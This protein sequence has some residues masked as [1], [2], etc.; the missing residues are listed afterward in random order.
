MPQKRTA[1]T[2]VACDS[3]R[4]RKVKCDGAQPICNRC[5]ARG[6]LSPCHYNRLHH[7]SLLRE[8]IS[9]LESELSR[10]KDDSPRAL[11]STESKQPPWSDLSGTAARRE[12]KPPCECSP[13]TSCIKTECSMLSP[14][15]DDEKLIGGF[16]REHSLGCAA[17]RSLYPPEIRAVQLSNRSK[18]EH[19]SNS[20]WLEAEKVPGMHI[21]WVNRTFL[22]M[23]AKGRWLAQQGL[24]ASAIMGDTCPTLYPHSHPSEDDAVDFWTVSRWATRFVDK[25]PNISHADRLACW[26]VIFVTFQWQICPTRETYRTIPDWYRPLDFQRYVPHMA[27]LDILIWPSARKYLAAHPQDFV[28]AIMSS[29]SVSWPHGDSKLYCTDLLTG[30]R[31]INPEFISW[32][33]DMEKWSVSEHTIASIPQLKGMIKTR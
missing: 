5:V 14:I 6:A 3:C 27:C 2:Q 30:K 9:Q 18:P 26:V 10:A 12:T 31:V 24:D 11:E 17:H 33:L 4:R 13:G 16:Y 1:V 15:T 19:L 20:I 7:I 29:I 32:C 21:E 28:E 22:E 25:F 8:H 23:R